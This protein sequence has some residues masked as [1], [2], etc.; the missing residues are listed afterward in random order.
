[1]KSWSL[2]NHFDPKPNE[3]L[4]NFRFNM[5]K[6]K[7]GEKAT[8]FLVTLR[9]LAANCDFGTHLEKALRNQFVFGLLDGK[10]QSRLLEKK[11]LNLNDAIT[12]ATASELAEIGGSELQGKSNETITVHKMAGKTKTTKTTNT[13]KIFSLR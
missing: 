10:L 3:L 1:M 8:D 2:Q 11:T 9:K 7:E 12:M 6:Q 13:K 4:E 5:R